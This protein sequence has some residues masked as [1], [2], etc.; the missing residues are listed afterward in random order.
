MD[1]RGK[2]AIVTGSAMG[3]GAAVALKLARRGVNVVINYSK[4]E[5]D[6]REVAGQC[7]ALGVETLA[8]KANIAEDADCR[9]LAAETLDKWGRIDILVNNAG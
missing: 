1:I 3:L 8:V 5:K 7:A 2:A 6:A 9:R 4:S